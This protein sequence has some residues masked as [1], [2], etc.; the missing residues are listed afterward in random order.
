MLH[1]TSIGESFFII[2]WLLFCFIVIAIESTFDANI[3]FDQ[4]LTEIICC[5]NFGYCLIFR[6]TM[7]D[8]PLFMGSS[9]WLLRWYEL[10]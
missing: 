5:L 9:D 7:T 1:L 2:D 4:M 8:Y 3:L 6:E 10:Q